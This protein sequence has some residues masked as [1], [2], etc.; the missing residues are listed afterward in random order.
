MQKNKLKYIRNMVYCAQKDG[1]RGNRCGNQDLE[2][3]E[4]GKK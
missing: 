4:G 1:F 3:L 2:R